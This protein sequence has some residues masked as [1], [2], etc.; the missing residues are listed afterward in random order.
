[1]NVN[2]AERGKD[3]QH[4]SRNPK[5]NPNGGERKDY[6]PHDLFTSNVAGAPYVGRLLHQVSVSVL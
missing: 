6:P 2:D 4:D 5:Q 1:V 3:R